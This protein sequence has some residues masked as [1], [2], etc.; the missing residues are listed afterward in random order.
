MAC[1]H[2]LQRVSDIEHQAGEMAEV[3]MLN[4]KKMGDDKAH[5]WAQCVA[6]AKAYSAPEKQA[7]RAAFIYKDI[8]GQWPAKGWN[9]ETTPRVEV[10]RPVLNK[11]QQ[12]NIAWKKSREVAA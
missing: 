5:V 6:Y 7:G 10:T 9:I 1:G 8:T 4:G 11:I 3:V 2:Q 12:K